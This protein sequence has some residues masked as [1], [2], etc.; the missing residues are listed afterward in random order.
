MIK[1]QI[2]KAAITGA[3]G[4]IGRR[5]KA[6]LEAEGYSVTGITRNDLAGPLNGLSNKIQ[7]CDIVINLAGAPIIARHTDAYKREIYSSRI[8][9]TRKL[10]NS[11]KLLKTPPRQLISASAIGIYSD[12]MVNT[13]TSYEYTE[14]FIADVCKDWEQEA[15]EAESFTKVAI[16]RLGIVLDG[17]E[18]ALPKMAFPFRLGAGGKLGSGNQM[19]SWIH[20]D[21]LVNAFMHII[22]NQ[23]K[24]VYNLTSPGYLR[25]EE[26]TR[27][28]G[29]ILKMPPFLTVPSFALRLIYGDGAKALLDGQA[30]YPERLLKEGFTFRY[31]I[32]E[33][34]LKD[35]LFSPR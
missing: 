19:F 25:N 13:E 20:I 16:V 4:F 11:L 14:G 23:T 29:H 9:T 3:T 5:L 26:L 22:H 33:D 21:D 18:G 34:A 15:H 30:V 24:G 17:K 10:V 35:T 12:N 7:D 27:I 6:R 28:L 31:T 1:Q 32:V 8:E 2:M